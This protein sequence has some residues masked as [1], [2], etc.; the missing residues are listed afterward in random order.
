MELSRNDYSAEVVSRDNYFGYEV[1]SR[2]NYFGYHDEEIDY[3]RQRESERFQKHVDA[4]LADDVLTKSEAISLV[5]AHNKMQAS[6]KAMLLKLLRKHGQESVIDQAEFRSIPTRSM[7]LKNNGEWVD[8][9]VTARKLPPPQST[10][11][12]GDTGWSIPKRPEPNV[13]H[14]FKETGTIDFGALIPS[15]KKTRFALIVGPSVIAVIL[16]LFGVI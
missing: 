8:A 9:G 4:L 1:V 16:R 7:V 14:M 13:D 15:G 11:I 2:D 10:T 6:A 12:R 3:L 5:K